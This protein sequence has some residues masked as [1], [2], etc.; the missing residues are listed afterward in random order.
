LAREQKGLEDEGATHTRAWASGLGFT[1]VVK[2]PTARAT[3]LRPGELERGR[4]ILEAKLDSMAI[5]RVIFTFKASVV[6]QLWALRR[7]RAHP[8]T[9]LAGAEVFVMPGPMEERG[10]VTIAIRALREW[11][12]GP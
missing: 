1:D 4:E 6:A 11:W 2:H 7:T 10:R 5:P 8:G 9:P 3:G 12:E